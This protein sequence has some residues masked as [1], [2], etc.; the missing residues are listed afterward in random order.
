MPRTRATDVELIA[1][2]KEF[3]TR[4]LAQPDNLQD[5]EGTKTTSP[6]WS[7]C[8]SVPCSPPIRR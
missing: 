2:A 4:G 8:T 1:D 6:A 7:R 5:L 3:L